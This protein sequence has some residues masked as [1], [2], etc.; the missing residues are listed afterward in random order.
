MDSKKARGYKSLLKLQ[1]N[2]LLNEGVLEMPE[3][4]QSR[5]KVNSY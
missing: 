3:E 2:S 1:M 4:D 5:E